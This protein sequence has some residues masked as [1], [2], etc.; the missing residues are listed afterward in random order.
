MTKARVFLIIGNR[1][2]TS[3]FNLNDLPGA[4]G[5]MDIICRFVAQSL[6]IS[7]GIRKDVEVFLLLLGNPDP[8]KAIKIDGS[9][10]K[11]M[12]PDER[13]IAGLIRKALKTDI[14]KEWT[15]SSTG[16]FVARK[17]LQE[18]FDE[19][20]GYRIFYLREDGVDIRELRGELHKENLAFLIGDH[21]GVSGEMENIIIQKADS[22]V[23]V[24]PVSLQADQ[25]VVIVHNELDR[26]ARESV[27][28][29]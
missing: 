26:L 9:R 18:L 21:L 5:R 25:C 22:I 3:T 6:F 4:G 28:E 17:N 13:N 24:S 2:A 7:H 1:A 14:G 8:P 15:E 29:E 27:E 16:I 12:A 11:S 19:L 20:T 10:V 23:S